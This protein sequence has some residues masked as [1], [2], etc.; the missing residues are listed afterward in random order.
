M[1]A[2]RLESKRREMAARYV[3][4]DELTDTEIAEKLGV[5]QRTLERWKR[6]DNFR[7]R[8]NTLV[9]VYAD[10]FLEQGLARKGQRL[11]VL[12]DLHD[13]MLRVIAERANDPS[14]AEVPGGKTGVVTRMLK[15]IGKGDDFQIVE[16][17]E[18]DTGTIREIRGVQEDVAKE[19]GQFIS[20]HEL[21]GKDG[22][23]LPSP[24]FNVTFKSADT[25]P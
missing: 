25:E 4:E 13:R 20:K 10:R 24:V 5:T 19:L 17:F 21:T 18:V 12:N 7:A 16:V 3:A 22:A 11:Q 9:N 2:N 1:S 14:I 23:P 8:V 6:Q 15:G